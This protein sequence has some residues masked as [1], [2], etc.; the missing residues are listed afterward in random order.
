[1]VSLCLPSR[2]GEGPGWC[3]RSARPHAAGSHRSYPPHQQGS[4][5]TGIPTILLYCKF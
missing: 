5:K 4:P 3:C 2:E 1:M